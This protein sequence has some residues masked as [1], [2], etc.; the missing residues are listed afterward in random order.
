MAGEPAG[1]LAAGKRDSNA[2]GAGR[3]AHPTFCGFAAGRGRRDGRGR[4]SYRRF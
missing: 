4:P 3:T 1:E 2:A